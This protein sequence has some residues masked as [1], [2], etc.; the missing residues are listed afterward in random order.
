MG[1]V[2]DVF[3]LPGKVVGGLTGETAAEAAMEAAG[4]S[5]QA[6][7]EAL[8]Y[9]KQKEAPILEMREQALPQLAE[10]FGLGQTREQML[11]GIMQGPQYQTALQQ[12][13]EAILRNQAAT[14]GLRSGGTQAALSQYAPNLLNQLYQQNL[15]GIQN[16]AGMKGYTPQIAQTMQNIG[17][18]QAA[19]ITGAAQAQ[20]QGMGNLINLGLGIGGLFAGGGKV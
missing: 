14:G 17:A 2:E 18:T 15:S 7:R 4:V 6:Q 11:E 16:I 10:I 19:G 12:G 3:E 20:Q 13:E 8:E 9:L 1:F 5:A